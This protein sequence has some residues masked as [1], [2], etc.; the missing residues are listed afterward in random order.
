VTKG[1]TKVHFL[2]IRFVSDDEG[3]EVLLASIGNPD[4]F[5]SNTLLITDE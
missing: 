5:L 1:V 4:E 2:T 3:W